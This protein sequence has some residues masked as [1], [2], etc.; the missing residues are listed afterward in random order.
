[1]QIIGECALLTFLEKKAVSGM[2]MMVCRKLLENEFLP[3][4]SPVHS[5]ISAQLNAA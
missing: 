3:T 4:R 1:M 2:T 5:I